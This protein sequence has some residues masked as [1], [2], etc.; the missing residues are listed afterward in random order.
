MSN[1]AGA[2][3]G[4]FRGGMAQ[5]Q[6]RPM[7]ATLGSQLGSMFGGGQPPTLGMPNTGGMGGLSRAVQ[8]AIG[9]GMASGRPMGGGMAFSP[10]K[11]P[12][13][14]RAY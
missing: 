14:A 6:P 7:L 1:L 2:M 11:R 12:P 10:P 8:G 13:M 5:P 9:G 3:Q 4:F